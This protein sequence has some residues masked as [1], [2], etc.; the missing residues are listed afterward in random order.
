MGVEEVVAVVGRALAEPKAVVGAGVVKDHNPLL[1]IFGLD[2]HRF[3]SSS[4]RGSLIEV[5]LATVFHAVL[6]D[7][8]S[9]SKQSI[10]VKPV[11]EVVTVADGSK[12]FPMVIVLQE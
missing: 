5:T 9:F 1:S 7:G 2:T 12:K 8:A 10:A 4:C 11:V 3:W 6:K